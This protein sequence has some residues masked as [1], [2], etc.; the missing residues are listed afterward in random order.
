VVFTVRID[1]KFGGNNNRAV[2]SKMKKNQSQN[3][4]IELN[5]KKKKKLK[6]KS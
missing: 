2:L 6:L 3:N 5:P 1:V 4:R